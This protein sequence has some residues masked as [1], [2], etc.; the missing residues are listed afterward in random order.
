MTS[1]EPFRVDRGLGQWQKRPGGHDPPVADD[2]RAVVERRTRRED[3][4]QQVRR[5]VAVD[6]DAGLRDF[7]EPGL[8]LEDDECALT[9]S[10]QSGSGSRD[11]NGNVDDSSLLRWRKQ[12]AE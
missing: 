8:T 12:P 5:D 2:D 11:L 1:P 6:H 3:R 9:V 4:A 10:R 7:L